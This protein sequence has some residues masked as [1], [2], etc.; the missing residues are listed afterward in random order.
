MWDDNGLDVLVWCCGLC[1]CLL[2]WLD[3]RLEWCEGVVEGAGAGEGCVCQPGRGQ[4]VEEVLVPQVVMREGVRY[5][6]GC[7]RT[8]LVSVRS[9]GG[10]VCRPLKLCVDSDFGR[11]GGDEW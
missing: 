10:S 4:S 7:V 11:F 8:R 9:T 3:S 2:G 5:W 6:S 1:G